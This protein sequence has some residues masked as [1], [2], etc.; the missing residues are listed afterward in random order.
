MQVNFSCDLPLAQMKTNLY[1]AARPWKNQS[2]T[3]CPDGNNRQEQPKTAKQQ[4][5]FLP[6]L[7]LLSWT[8]LTYLNYQVEHKNA[9]EF[10]EQQLDE[11]YKQLLSRQDN[12]LYRT[13]A[14]GRDCIISAEKNPEGFICHT[15]NDNQDVMQ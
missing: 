15:D 5:L 6:A 3:S 2:N 8:L 9:L 13:K 12:T 1:F 11:E 14:Q 7:F 10:A 4:L